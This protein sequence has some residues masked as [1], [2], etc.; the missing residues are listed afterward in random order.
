[1]GVAANYKGGIKQ[2][3]PSGTTVRR[4][5]GLSGPVKRRLTCLHGVS[6][7]YRF[8]TVS[9]RAGAPLTTT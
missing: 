5:R 7:L 6:K 9:A 4:A 8:S 3:A 1:M 2:N